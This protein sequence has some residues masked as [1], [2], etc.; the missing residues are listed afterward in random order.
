MTNRN[1]LLAG[2]LLVVGVLAVVLAAPSGPG[3]GQATGVNQL[4]VTE[5]T[6]DDGLQDPGAEAWADVEGETVVLSS[7]ES[8]LPGAQDTSVS[9]ADVETAY[10]DERLYVRLS[11]DDPAANQE[12]DDPTAFVDG[13]AVQIPFEQADEPPIE[14]GSEKQP[15]NVWF[16]T[17]DGETEELHAGGLGS[18]TQ[19]NDTAVTTEAEYADGEWHVVFSRELSTDDRYRTDIDTDQR[20]N[21]AFAVFDGESDERGGVKAASEWHHYPLDPDPGPTA[22]ELVL[23]TVG[24]LAIV[25]VLVVTVYGIKNVE[26]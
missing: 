22:F 25:G 6:A 2:A 14:M 9:R 21:V 15:V 19:L 18:T 16:W 4:P 26:R 3:L 8:G 12:I 17:A 13:V 10:T 23:W 20:L 5:M 7:A 11:W 1:V 24:G